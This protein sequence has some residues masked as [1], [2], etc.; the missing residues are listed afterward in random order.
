M[1]APTIPA[2][3]ALAAL[4]DAALIEALR[5]GTPGAWDAYEHRLR[6][7]LSE[8]LA[9]AW[10]RSD[11]EH[12]DR[13][14]LVDD[15]LVELAVALVDG[16]WKPARLVA[17]ACVWM[18]HR[19]LRRHRSATRQRRWHEDATVVFNGESIV[20]SIHSEYT[21][22]SSTGAE[23]AYAAHTTSA[24][25]AS[26]VPLGPASEDTRPWVSA[27]WDALART[28]TVADWQVLT[29]ASDGTSHRA[30]AAILGCSQAAAEKRF[31]RAMARA[32]KATPAC[33]AELPPAD[34]S[35]AAR[36]LARAGAS[37][38]VRA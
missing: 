18:R 31:Q 26:D 4:S 3:P 15:V 1:S 25:A 6:G 34:R 16:Q 29:L 14:E 11:A 36:C 13:K 21:V 30:A 8:A 24:D 27:W 17:F 20:Q 37:C 23:W 2:A 5:R 32:R 7:P 35:Q 38:E 33:L 22:R 10:R 12:S 19:L 28:L 9:L